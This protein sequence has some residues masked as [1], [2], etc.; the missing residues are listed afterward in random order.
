[1]NNHIF[2]VRVYYEDTDSGGVVYYANYLRFA[3]RARTEWLREKGYKQADL[4][5]KQ[6]IG[7]VVRKCNIEY[8]KPAFLDDI[9]QIE[10]SVVEKSSSSIKMQQIITK[11]NDDSQKQTI[12]T[13]EVLLVCINKQFRPQKI[14]LNLE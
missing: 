12:S 1:M 8:F 2:N 5:D 7:F 13:I 14:L 11:L 10:T 9:L 4:W 3:E 6:G